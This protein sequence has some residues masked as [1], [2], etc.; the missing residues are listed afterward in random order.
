MRLQIL[1]RMDS[2]GQNRQSL[3]GTQALIDFYLND[4]GGNLTEN[5][6]E[7]PSHSSCTDWAAR[8]LCPVL[9]AVP[10]NWGQRTMPALGPNLRIRPEIS[11]SKTDP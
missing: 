1:I 2:R 7:F 9:E 5:L 3:M 6:S 11:T 4:T 10:G 8:P